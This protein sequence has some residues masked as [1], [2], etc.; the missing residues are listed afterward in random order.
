MDKKKIAY[1]ALGKAAKLTYKG[2]AFA[3]KTVY[4]HRHEAA[5]AA[6]GVV[7]QSVDLARDLTG[8]TITEKDFVKQLQ[9]L[10]EQSRQYGRIIQNK[11][12]ALSE[13]DRITILDS[14][15]ASSNYVDA[16]GWGSQIIP[17]DIQQAY[18]RAYPDLAQQES[19]QDAVAHADDSELQGF[20][21]GIKGKL[22]EMRYADYLNDGHLPAGFTAK[23]ADSPTNP[24]WDIGIYDGNGILNEELQLK[25]TDSVQYV[26]EALE[27]YPHIDIV[28]TD[29]VYSQLAMQGFSDH[30]T[31]SGISDS[32]LTDFVH[33]SLSQAN[34]EF[35]W[36]PSLLPFLIIGFFVGRKSDLT[37]Y[38]KGKE[39]G[40]RSVKSYIAHICGGAVLLVTHTW[41]LGLL[42]AVGSRLVMGH[43]KSRR[44]RYEALKK[45]VKKNEHVL[46]R[47]KIQ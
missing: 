18:E 36:M 43:F 7:R 1:K 41:W 31:D 34:V 2:G 8:V 5:G 32:E 17:D 16:Y 6:V 37:D 28:T 14:L 9:R 47:L 27:K 44:E 22:F 25:A 45:M 39:F 29:E 13:N 15:L 3:A 10:E 19:L 20:I 26:Q 4:D 35:D 11:R 21:A 23:L 12:Q 24:G 33:E 30:V 46:R 40:H 38:E 42:G